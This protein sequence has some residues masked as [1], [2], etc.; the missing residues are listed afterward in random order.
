[1]TMTHPL[2]FR[3][4]PNAR[5]I[6]E[7]DGFDTRQIGTIAG[8]S[9]G[10]KW[11]VL[12]RIDRVIAEV[13]LPAINTPT[14][15]LGSSIGAWR[16]AC[17]AQSDPL[18][19]LERFEASYVDQAYSE[20]PDIHEVTARSHEILDVV[21]GES[22]IEEILS[23][24][25]LRP[26]V[27][28]V[29]CGSLTAS[30]NPLLLAGSLMTAA[31]GNIVSRRALG[32]FF[33]RALFYDA[34]DIPPFIDQPGFPIDR[35]KISHDN[36]R[37]AVLAS[38]AIPLVLKG[39]TNI[40]GAPAGRYRDGG[41]IDYHLDVKTSEKE[42]ITLYPHFFDYLKPGWFDKSLSWRRNSAENTRNTLLICPSAEF[43]RKLPNGKIPDRSDFKTMTPDERR[44]AW[45]K[46]IDASEMLADDL[47]EVLAN[48]TLPSRLE[49][50]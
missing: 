20:S 33:R 21:L 15:L 2:R 42:R 10:A 12:S 28:T 34:R 39:V 35:I 18:A 24:R 23:N 1:M 5:N 29:R 38:G 26:H 22:G 13:I 11:L 48:G 47:R 17:Y 43:V 46:T 3:A 8:A 4:G 41:I 37:D 16:F 44:V 31:A 40:P 25:F 45:R 36:Y 27:M 19:A 6:I 49:T 14:H 32:G 9:G 7:R 30:E 50:L